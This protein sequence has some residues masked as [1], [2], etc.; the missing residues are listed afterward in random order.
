MFCSI[1]IKNTIEKHPFF[2]HL[3]VSPDFKGWSAMHLHP[4]PLLCRACLSINRYYRPVLKMDNSSLTWVCDVTAPCET[5]RLTERGSL[6]QCF[7][8]SC[9]LRQTK[10][11]LSSTLFSSYV[12]FNSL[13]LSSCITDHIRNL[14]WFRDEIQQCLCNP[15]SEGGS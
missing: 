12:S 6:L 1:C 13:R 9:H 5:E 3:S 8:V 2:N 11:M 4:T 7:G 10:T 14:D 15:I